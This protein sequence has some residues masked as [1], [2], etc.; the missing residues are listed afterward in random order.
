MKCFE[1]QSNRV[2]GFVPIPFIP[3]AGKFCSNSGG[4]DK[5]VTAVRILT[6]PLT[7]KFRVKN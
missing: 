1:V 5:T 7:Y 3:H 2:K 4:S 6:T